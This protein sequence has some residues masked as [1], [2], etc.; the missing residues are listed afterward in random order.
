M[1]PQHAG[2]PI[3][4]APPSGAGA[5]YTPRHASAG[6][7]WLFDHRDRWGLNMD[8]LGVLLGGVPR[9]TL[10]AWRQKV[11]AGQDIEVPRDVMERISLLLGIHKSLTLMTP[12][13]HEH[14]ADHWFQ[15]PVELMGLRNTSIRDYLLERGSMDALYYIRRSLDAMR[16]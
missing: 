11:L 2:T 5:A 8:Q 9:R 6:L 12:D 7:R 4:S 1:L 10:N 3:D 13:N 14:L 15:Q 16:G